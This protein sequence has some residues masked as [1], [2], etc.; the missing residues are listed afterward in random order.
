PYPRG[1]PPDF[2]PSRS[3]C[4]AVPDPGYDD[5]IVSSDNWYAFLDPGEVAAVP[6]EGAAG[7]SLQLFGYPDVFVGRFPVGNDIELVA[8]VTKIMRFEDPDIDDTWRR[9][10]VLLADDA[11]SGG[12]NDY[13]YRSYEREFEW[14][15][16]RTAVEIEES[17]P[18]GF[19]ISTVNLA[20]W[21]DG[22]HDIEE[23]GP[24]AYSK[25]EIAT[26]AHC[27]PYLIRRLNEGCLLFTFQGHA[28]RA[29]LAKEAPFATLGTY[30]DQDSL[31]SRLPFVFTGFG[32]HISEFAR[33]S[34]LSRHPEG[35][36]G[37]CLSEQLLFKPGSGAVGTYASSAFEYLDQ[38]AVFCERLHREI[39]QSPPA[40][41][42][43]P[44]NKYTGAHWILAEAITK[45]LIEHL[46]ATWYGFDQAIRYTILGDPMLDIDPGPPVMKLEADW[47]EGW[48]EIHPDSMH[49][50][51]GTNDCLLRF[52]TSDVIAL[53]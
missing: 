21:T 32:C 50:Q 30:S 26:R 43:P 20:H 15:I 5:E 14:S 33:L 11:W 7:A 49:A 12:G 29:N 25:A 38:N 35:E 41:S 47:G 39:F 42:V 45:A 10:I 36:N 37:D 34:E 24:S 48:K 8:L 9:N 17:L 23:W 18:N 40:D 22:A 19:N 53:G 1:S 3:I 52:T 44:D 16:G 28:A 27:T 13:R 51:N 31:R 6:A 2:I 46:D 4:V